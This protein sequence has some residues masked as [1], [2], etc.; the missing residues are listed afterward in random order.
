MGR[1]ELQMWI[2]VDSSELFVVIYTTQ[3]SYSSI[4][5]IASKIKQGHGIRYL[6]TPPLLA[7]VNPI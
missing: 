1:N 7:Q 5:G 4:R 6:L 3:S 2:D